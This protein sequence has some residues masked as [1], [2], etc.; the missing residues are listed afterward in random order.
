MIKVSIFILIMIIAIGIHYYI[1]YYK[2]VRAN[3]VNETLSNMC[4]IPLHKKNV[5]KKLDEIPNYDIETGAETSSNRPKINLLDM[6]MHMHSH[7]NMNKQQTLHSIISPNSEIKSNVRHST[8]CTYTPSNDFVYQN[9]R[10]F[11]PGGSNQT[12]DYMSSKF[13][14]DNLYQASFFK[15]CPIKNRIVYT[16][17]PNHTYSS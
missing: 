7:H 3:T 8:L 6:H 17:R 1:F 2:P 10:P 15:F 11:E 13:L 16:N 12:M 4:M 9:D 5:A 14:N